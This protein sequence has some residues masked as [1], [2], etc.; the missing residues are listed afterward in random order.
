MKQVSIFAIPSLCFALIS[1]IASLAAPLSFQ[2]TDL[3]VGS[4]FGIND[5]GQVVGS[6]GGVSGP[7]IWS[8]SGG[9]VPLTTS[10]GLNQFDIAG[11]SAINNAGQISGTVRSSNFFQSAGAFWANPNSLVILPN[12]RQDNNTSA[13]NN[14]GLIV[15]TGSTS[16]YSSP[17]SWQNG[18][19][20]DLPLLGYYPPT[21][22]QGDA[23]DVNDIG[24]IV[25]SSSNPDSV[26]R[27]AVYWENGTV[28]DL[29]MLPGDQYSKAYAVNNKGEIVGVS[30]G[31]SGTQTFLWSALGGMTSIGN[32]HGLETLPTAMN[33]SSWVVGN[34]FTGSNTTPFLW[35]PGEAITDLNSFAYLANSSFSS[36]TYATDINS[37]GEVVGYG[38]GK[39]GLQHAFLIS[40]V[41]EVH[42]WLF[43]LAGV[44]FM[45]W[46][47]FKVNDK[48]VIS[49]AK[50]FAGFSAMHKSQISFCGSQVA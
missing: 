7:V 48:K 31:A 40:P 2:I 22:P 14:S 41:P 24:V 49:R 32:L 11:A 12:T 6:F 8:R 38:L 45:W 26:D 9:V 18:V 15:G 17:T 43:L 30:G 25:G 29:G 39:D 13:I 16:R 37:L 10:T 50:H 44:I 21:G 27:H 36:L 20:S 47:L 4:A 35:R 28:H 33:D 34:A 3:G 46:R 42:T 1:P 5:N 23:N 19:G